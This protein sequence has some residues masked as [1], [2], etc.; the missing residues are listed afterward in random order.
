[1]LI[2]PDADSNR[3]SGELP[4][5]T[6]TSANASNNEADLG[7]LGDLMELIHA[8]P[9]GAL[10]S[11]YHRGL[12]SGFM[13]SPAMVATAT[14]RPSSTSLKTVQDT[15]TAQGRSPAKA[16]IAKSANREA[17]STPIAS[18]RASITVPNATAAPLPLSTPVKQK[19]S[20]RSS[21]GSSHQPFTQQSS[22]TIHAST[23]G[24]R[25]LIDSPRHG[26]GFAAF[27][28]PKEIYVLGHWT[29]AVLAFIGCDQEVVPIIEARLVHF[30]YDEDD[31][32]AASFLGG[33]YYD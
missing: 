12:P 29:K 20:L 33:G 17:T 22:S 1:M 8:L 24:R 16:P 6:V 31:S 32:R 14:Q 30:S 7:T 26:I 10:E 15:S 5:A 21:A 3:D 13:T 2:V 11:A 27:S 9:P 18:P 19:A 28:A 25:T 23:S 4:S